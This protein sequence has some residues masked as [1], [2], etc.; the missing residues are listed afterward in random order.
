MDSD[1]D[2]PGVS[3]AFAA[4]GP[5]SPPQAAPEQLSML[6][7]LL[8][9]AVRS[10]ASLTAAAEAVKRDGPGRPKG[11]SNK[12][13]Q[14]WQEY[15]GKRYTSPLETLV[16]YQSMSPKELLMVLELWSPDPAQP[17]ATPPG[18]LIKWA[19]DYIRICAKEAAP[20]LHARLGNVVQDDE[21]NDLPVL[22]VGV[23]AR[24]GGGQPGDGAKI[25]EGAYTI[26]ARPADVRTQS[27][28]PLS[29]EG[30]SASTD[31]PSTESAK[32]LNNQGET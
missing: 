10:T 26:D 23:I 7:E 21:G 3:A 31:G 22:A 25:A 13:T 2:K 12:R 9:P 5:G 4:T 16:A 8:G 28:Q 27:N 24:P 19:A 29:D 15:L 6:D 32:P 20:F 17:D 11:S 18:G 14:E 30:D 1:T